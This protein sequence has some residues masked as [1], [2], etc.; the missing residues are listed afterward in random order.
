MLPQ[1]A[2]VGFRMGLRYAPCERL[3]PHSGFPIR[4]FYLSSGVFSW[5]RFFVDLRFTTKGAVPLLS[6]F[7]KDHYSLAGYISST[8]FY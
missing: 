7:E 1:G 4:P 5:H 2:L 8:L 6:G 3:T